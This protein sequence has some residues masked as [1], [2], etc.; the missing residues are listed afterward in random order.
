MCILFYILKYIYAYTWYY[1]LVVI[2]EKWYVYNI[3][4]IILQQILGGMLLLILIWNHHKQQVTTNS[5]KKK[6]QVTT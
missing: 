2:I 6:Q 4:K 5:K 3:F 1:N